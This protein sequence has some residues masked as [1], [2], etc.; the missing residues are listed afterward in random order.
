MDMRRITASTILAILMMMPAVARPSPRSPLVLIWFFA[1]MHRIRPTLEIRN[2]KMK[3]TT[4]IVFIF[5]LTGY[6]ALLAEGV[7]YAP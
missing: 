4:A 7:P 6:G 5:G 2:E 1:I 3:P